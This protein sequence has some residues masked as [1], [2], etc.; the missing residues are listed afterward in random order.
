MCSLVQSDPI[1]SKET[2]DR[3][4]RPTR[5]LLGLGGC[6]HVTTQQDLASIRDDVTSFARVV[7]DDGPV[8]SGGRAAAGCAALRSAVGDVVKPGGTSTNRKPAGE[9]A[10]TGRTGRSNP[11]DCRAGA[12]NSQEFHRGAGP[13]GGSRRRLADQSEE[14]CRPRWLLGEARLRRSAGLVP[15]DRIEAA[16]AHESVAPVHDGVAC[17]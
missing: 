6:R 3:T 13:R 9:N 8:A 11:G 4:A 2:G 10:A 7:R 12:E 17:R 16:S 1:P 5:F 14:G 15:R